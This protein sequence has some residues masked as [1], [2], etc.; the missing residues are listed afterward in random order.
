MHARV[1]GR[2][3]PL[4]QERFQICTGG[5]KPTI[6][7]FCSEK[8]QIQAR[9][10]RC[11]WSDNFVLMRI[12]Q[13]VPSLCG[14]RRP[15]RHWGQKGRAP[16]TPA[17]T[18]TSCPTRPRP[19]PSWSDVGAD[20]DTIVCMAPVPYINVVLF[21]RGFSTTRLRSGPRRPPC[22]RRLALTIMRRRYFARSIGPF[23][24]DREGGLPV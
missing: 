20:K 10:G 24:A 7:L 18:T 14:L 5:K 4:T 21:D 13:T 8:S 11:M 1:R 23:Q 17:T 2:C 19:R 6:V 15:G 3:H 12:Y 22:G 16:R 9:K